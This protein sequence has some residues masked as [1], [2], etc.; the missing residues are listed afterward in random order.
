MSGK[1]PLSSIIARQVQHML[2][3]WACCHLHTSN[4]DLDGTGVG[5]IKHAKID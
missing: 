2:A 4:I 1:A 3:F 5:A